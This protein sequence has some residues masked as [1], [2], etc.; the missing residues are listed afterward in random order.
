MRGKPPWVAAD[1]AYATAAFLKP[2][3]AAGVTVVRR[4]R[5][6]AALCSLPGPRRAGQRGRPRAYGAH[7]ISP[8]KR[9]GQRRGWRTGTVDLS[10]RPAAK[11]YETFRATRRPA[12][13]EIRGVLVQETRGW[14]ALFCTAPAA[15]VADLLG[16]VA[17]R[18]RPAAAFRDVKQVVGAGQPQV[19][20]V[21]T[22][23]GAL[24]VCLWTY[25]RPEAWA[26]GRPAEGRADRPG[27][28]WGDPKRRPSHADERRSLRR[29]LLA[30]EIRDGLR[31]GRT[32]EDLSG[33][34]ERLLNLAA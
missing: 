28:L 23:I 27:S 30:A 25:P 31:A 20:K 15:G 11:T 18:L 4:R 14:V 6:D 2:V 1:G 26:W 34:A 12:G 13:G 16:A 19:R 8:A 5:T 9:A 22:N 7:R 24:H 17:D 29:E 3:L 33:A 32:A 21:A 10:G